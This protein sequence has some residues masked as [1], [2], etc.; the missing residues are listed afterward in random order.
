MEYIYNS[1]VG[2]LLI[3]YN[4]DY[5]TGLH[6]REEQTK[7]FVDNEI[8]SKCIAQLDAYFAGDLQDF[9]LPL[10]PTGTDFQRSVWSA[11]CKIEYGKTATYGA[12]AAIVG[13]P[14]ASRAVGGANNKNP[15]AI[16]IP[17]HR[18]IGASGKMVGYAG[19]MERKTW[20][21]THER[22]NLL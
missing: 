18:V 9:D 15:I 16:I 4:D 20:L 13:N 6:F 10:K 11:L 7:A 14:K 2:K 8:I 5:I 3:S 1:P 12:I 17:C 21:L 22:N 19:G